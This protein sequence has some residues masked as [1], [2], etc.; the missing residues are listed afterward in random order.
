V[1]SCVAL[2][3]EVVAYFIST[4]LQRGGTEVDRTAL[5]HFNGFLSR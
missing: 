1:I 4:S 3:F 5:D 2:D